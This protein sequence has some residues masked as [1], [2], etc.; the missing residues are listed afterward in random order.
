MILNF[1]CLYLYLYLSTILCYSI[2]LL[3]LATFSKSD[4]HIIGKYETRYKY[5]QHTRVAL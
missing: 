3:A 1:F 5:L 2:Y 4:F